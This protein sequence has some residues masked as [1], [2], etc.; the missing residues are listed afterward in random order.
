MRGLFT[1]LLLMTL[2]MRVHAETET[3]LALVIHQQH[4]T[5][6]LS[7]VELAEAEADQVASA[8]EDTGFT[9]IR[10]DNLTRKE[11]DDAL[12]DFRVTVDRAG[13][14][15]VGFIYYTGH[16]AQNPETHDS[17]LL[18]I[19][20]QMRV[21]SDF[22]K[23]GVSLADQ[24]DY[25][26]ATGAK[27]IFMVF[28][29]CRNVP[30]VPGYKSDMKGLGRISA[31][32]EML[33]AYSTDLGAL[34]KAGVYAPILAEEIR[35]YGQS[36]EQVFIETQKRVAQATLDT[37]NPQRPWTDIK[38]YNNF[39]FNTTPGNAILGDRAN[40]RGIN[41]YINKDYLGAAKGYREACDF[42]NP[43]GC[44]GLGYLHERGLGVEKS[45]EDAVEMY[46]RGCELGDAVGCGNLA[47]MY[48]N[49]LGVAAS[50]E[51][52]IELNTTACEM[53]HDNSCSHLGAVYSQDKTPA[54]Y[55]KA[56]Q[57]FQNMCDE[58]RIVGC[59]NLGV[60]YENGEGVA[61]DYATAF[62]LYTRGCDGANAQA[63]SNLGV[64]QLF[65]RG[66]PENLSA[67]LKLFEKACAG[68][69]ANGCTYAGQIM[70]VDF[71]GVPNLN[72]QGLDY[73][74][75]GCSG[76]DNRACQWLGQ[77]GWQP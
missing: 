9:V 26:G 24:R 66:V 71:P 54:G 6:S 58:D 2:C 62:D 68:G 43:L 35:R 77:N 25:F 13:P 73:M 10:R 45:L 33:I 8:L 63:C 57:L 30:N 49:G 60:M 52:S 4:Y 41:A 18:G 7:E 70:I 51:K 61:Q 14:E 42:G 11:L 23:Y 15:A 39:T 38:I 53:G 76:G 72:Q 59:T 67:A 31:A 65:G 17:Y 56:R 16:G 3:R 74:R 1:F 50:I 37:S 29:A 47:W 20:A 64:M 36:A 75:K 27:A 69:F 5:G 32:P 48:Q 55:E 28:D 22:A 19:D 40:R 34:A 12:D 46:D 21:A 44:T